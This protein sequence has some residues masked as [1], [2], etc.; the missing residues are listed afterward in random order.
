MWPG[1]AQLEWIIHHVVF[2]SHLFMPYLFKIEVFQQMKKKTPKTMGKQVFRFRFLYSSS[3]FLSY[4]N[5][6]RK[7]VSSY[8]P[9]FLCAIHL[10]TSLSFLFDVALADRRMNYNVTCLESNWVMYAWGMQCLGVSMWKKYINIYV[11]ILYIHTYI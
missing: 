7:V 4:I 8:P 1:M 3:R 5:V 9:G 11:Y 2:S 10:V 6:Q